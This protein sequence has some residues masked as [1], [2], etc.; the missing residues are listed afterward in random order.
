M[1]GRERWELDQEMTFEIE[2][3]SSMAFISTLYCSIAEWLTINSLLYT[4]STVQYYTLLHCFANP[5][6]WRDWKMCWLFCTVAARHPGL[7]G[8][9]VLVCLSILSRSSC[10]LSLGVLWLMQLTALVTNHWALNSSSGSTPRPALPTHGACCY[11][12]Q[13]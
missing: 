6:L 11:G 9:E 8:V 3:S 2:P 12:E 7:T 10:L 4:S 5:M 1:D 13:S